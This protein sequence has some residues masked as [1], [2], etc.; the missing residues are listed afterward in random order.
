MV[1]ILWFQ[2]FTILKWQHS[3]VVIEANMSGVFK[4]NAPPNVTWI[5]E[6]I[7]EVAKGHFTECKWYIFQFQTGYVAVYNCQNSLKIYYVDY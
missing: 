4:R 2:Q 5:R 3:S 7:T 6:L 1:H